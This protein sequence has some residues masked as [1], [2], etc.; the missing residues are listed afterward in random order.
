MKETYGF[1][2]FNKLQ[3]RETKELNRKGVTQSIRSYFE[4]AIQ[5]K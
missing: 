3:E 1:K 4:Y 2:E 5:I